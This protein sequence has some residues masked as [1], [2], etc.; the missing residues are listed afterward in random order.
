MLKHTLNTLLAPLTTSSLAK[1][2]L[3][4]GHQ[5]IGNSFL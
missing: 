5:L 3:Q 1:P 2:H 4:S